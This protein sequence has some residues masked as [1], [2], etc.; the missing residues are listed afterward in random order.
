MI[1]YPEQ[2]HDLLIF[3]RNSEYL[4]STLMH[5]AIFSSYF[6]VK[7]VSTTIL[8]FPIIFQIVKIILG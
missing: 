5:S 6:S 4:F 3:F 8:H 7:F 1:V 2:F